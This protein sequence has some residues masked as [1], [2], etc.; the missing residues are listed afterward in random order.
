ME[1]LAHIKEQSR[2]NLSSYGPQRMTEELKELGMPIGYRRVG[3]LM[4]E[5]NIR[6]ERS[7]K[8]KVTTTARQAIAK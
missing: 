6:V 8:Y 3:R 1:V 4:R 7:K 2:L 5:N